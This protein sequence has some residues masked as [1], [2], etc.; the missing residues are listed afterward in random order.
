MSYEIEYEL[1][2]SRKQHLKNFAIFKKQT[3]EITLENT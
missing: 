2:T 1:C 3:P